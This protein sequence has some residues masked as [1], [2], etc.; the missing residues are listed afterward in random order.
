MAIAM[1]VSLP[2]TRASPHHAVAR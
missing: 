2:D 1:N